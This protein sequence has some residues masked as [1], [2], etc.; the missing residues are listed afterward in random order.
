M[1]S[2][3][4]TWP[5][6]FVLVACA[7]HDGTPLDGPGTV[8][9]DLHC[10]LDDAAAE[11]TCAASGPT[12]ELGPPLAC[13]GLPLQPEEEERYQAQVSEGTL[14]CHCICE[15]DRRACARP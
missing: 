8:R 5:A 10:T 13:G 7:A 15:A 14:A 3:V 12:C 4:R 6:A 2:I 1:R 9:H 11:K